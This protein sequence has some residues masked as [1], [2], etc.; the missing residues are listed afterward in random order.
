MLAIY[1]SLARIAQAEF[2]DVVTG[3]DYIGGTSSSPNKLRLAFTE[4]SFMDIWL[5][6][7]GDY[8]YHWER[9]RQTGQTFRWD[10]APHFPK[11]STFPAH[12][13]DGD[14]STVAENT[15]STNPQSALRE[16]LE[17]VRRYLR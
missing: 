3:T 17:F 12:F 1:Q 13:H 6:A 9:R 8:A 7:D 4:G 15:L 5:S 2:S 14:E 11:I 16:I 10:N